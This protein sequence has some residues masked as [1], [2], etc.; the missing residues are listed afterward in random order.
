[1]SKVY[2]DRKIAY[3]GVIGDT[4]DVVSVSMSDIVLDSG[5]PA[6]SLSLGG[7]ESD[8]SL[9]ALFAL[10]E[11]SGLLIDELSTLVDAKPSDLSK[12]YLTKWVAMLKACGIKE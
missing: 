1:M 6:V 5:T 4:N 11:V 7:E 10:H 12:P 8:I 2:I 3:T 9:Q